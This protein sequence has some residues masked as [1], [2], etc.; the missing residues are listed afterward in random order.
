MCSV[1]ESQLMVRYL[2]AKFSSLEHGCGTGSC[3][4]ALHL[5]SA[6][7]LNNTLERFT[8]VAPD[9]ACIMCNNEFGISLKVFFFLLT[10]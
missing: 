10:T 2:A 6:R 8:S 1:E 5:P 9:D 3:T 4:R 7:W